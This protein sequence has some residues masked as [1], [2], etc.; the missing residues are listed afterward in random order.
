LIARFPLAA[1]FA[2]AIALGGGVV[3]L[4]MQGLLPA[5]MTVGAA[6]SASLAGVLMTALVDGRAGLKQLFRQLRIR[7]VSAGYW[8]FAFLYLV[9]AVLLGALANPLF[10][11]DRLAL[12]NFQP[13]FAIV[14]MYIL[15]F[16]IAGLGQELGW[17][18]FLIPR[19][20]SRYSALTAAVMRAVL[21][22]IWHL[23]L[24]LYSRLDPQ[25]FPSIPYGSW[26]AQI[27][28]PAALAVMLVMFLL[29]WSIFFT[30]MYNNT[31]GNLL[32]VAILHGS[33]IW[34]PYWM[35]STGVNPDNINNYWGYGTV[36]LLT[37]LLIVVITG[38][39]NLSR[40]ERRVGSQPQ[41][42]H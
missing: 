40:R 37:A 14:P 9:P 7:Q 36:L 34:L 30:W 13:A 38:R 19:L 16:F 24:L 5:G 2:L 28:F 27:G 8:V 41:G 32:L 39:E 11:G 4:V 23:P 21:V 22:G 35:L 17:T 10:N 1:F 3:W 26:I 12:G 31:G 42:T 33:E 20:Q 18:G 29:P 25:A 6:I 15:F